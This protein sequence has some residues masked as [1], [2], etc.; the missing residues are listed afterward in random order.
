MLREGSGRP[1][2][3]TGGT[4]SCGAALCGLGGARGRVGGVQ[5][6]EWRTPGWSGGS[7]AC[8][9]GGVIAVPCLH[10]GCSTEGR[11]AEHRQMRA[12]GGAWC[13]GVELGSIRVAGGSSRT[14]WGAAL[15]LVWDKLAWWWHAHAIAS[16]S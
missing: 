11:P 6:M 8:W 7:R 3:A 15:L 12:G 5:G 2:L 1:C 10:A 4:G 16:S 13:D 9:S 14:R